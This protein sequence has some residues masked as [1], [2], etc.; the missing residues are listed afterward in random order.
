VA[1]AKKSGARLV[2][3]RRKLRQI[4]GPGGEAVV[5]AL[6]KIAPDLARY[7]V[8]FAFGDVYTRGGLSLKERQIATVAALVALG[9]SQPQLR[10]HIQGA[11]NVGCSRRDV[12][13]VI[14]QMSLYAGFPAA[15]NAAYSAGE[16]FRERD[17][18]GLKD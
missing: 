8:E 15:S 10:S 13:E 1:K 18:K 3:G 17:A 2:R 9:H 12:L 4:H 16:V 14:I 7:I 11:L 5:A 6:G